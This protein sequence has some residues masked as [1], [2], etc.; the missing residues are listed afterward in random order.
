MTKKEHLVLVY[1]MELHAK[2]AELSASNCRMIQK[3]INTLASCIGIMIKCTNQD[4][5]EYR[6]ELDELGKIT[7]KMRVLDPYR[8]SD[9][10]FQHDYEQL[11][12]MLQAY[13]D[14]IEAMPDDD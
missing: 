11:T 7:E 5:S 10:G 4:W 8:R 3:R 1:F 2:Q 12:G 14:M 13:K 9:S 6:E